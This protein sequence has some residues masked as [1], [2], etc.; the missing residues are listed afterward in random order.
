[1]TALPPVDG[2]LF[3]IDDTL[4][5]TREA[6]GHALSAVARRY[7]PA[8]APERDDELVTSWRADAHDQY[9]AYTRGETTY[10]AQRMA[11]ANDLHAEFGGPVLDDEAYDA[12]DD[13]FDAAFRDAWLAHDDASE[14]VDALLDAG[15]VVGALSNA[16]TAYQV[17]KLERAG[18]GDRVPMLV[19]V[20]TLGYG[21]PDPRAFAEACRRLGTDPART[22]YVGDDVVLDAIA[23]RDAGLVG[24]W[25]DR[26]GD[27][28]HTVTDEQLAAVQARITSL[29]ELPALLGVSQETVAR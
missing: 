3:D 13:L 11:R 27:R 5:A 8:V 23:S 28:R 18:L 21:K 29:R 2:V 9:G 16:A 1:M 25:I 26:P 24:V 14:V 17:A 7:L 10:R 6:F 4:V 19:G 22:A 12:W 20:D 15:L